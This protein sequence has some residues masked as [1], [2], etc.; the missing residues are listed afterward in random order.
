[1]RRRRAPKRKIDPDPRF[2]DKIVAKLI[3]IVME[4]G[5]KSTAKG[6][7]YGAMDI[8]KEKTGKEPLEVLK[9]AVD[10]VRP[11]LETKSRRVGGATYQVPMT[12]RPDRGYTLALRW[13]RLYS[14]QRKGKPMMVKLAQEILDSYQ[15]TGTS[16]KKREDIHKMAESNRAFAHYRW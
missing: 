13:M 15:K 3:N 1:M 5:K 16:F 10:N 8:V 2:N 7:V 14:R 4:R 9:Q 6:I 12:V 11:L